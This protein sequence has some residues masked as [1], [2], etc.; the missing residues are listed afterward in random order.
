MVFMGK[1]ERERQRE[2]ERER[3]RA[4]CPIAL[5]TSTQKHGNYEGCGFLSRATLMI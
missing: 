3:E 2:R 4:F 5:T 1:M